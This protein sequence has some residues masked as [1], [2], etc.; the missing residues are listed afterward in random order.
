MMERVVSSEGTGRKAAITGY[1]V[2]GKTGTAKKV[3]GKGYEEGHYRSTF[4]GII[5]ASSPKLVAII[6]IDD[7]KSGEYSGGDVAA[8][9]FSKVMESVVRLLNIPP[10]NT[11]EINHDVFLS[12]KSKEEHLRIL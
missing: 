5:P 12:K 9:I 3:S 4:A 8:P 6:T 10:D 7:P 1:R 11:N 2:A